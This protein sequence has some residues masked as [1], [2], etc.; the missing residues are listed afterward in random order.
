[1]DLDDIFD[2][3]HKRRNQ[4]YDHDYRHYDNYRHENEYKS[5][6]SHE[7]QND[8]KLEFLNQLRNNPKL[9]ILLISIAGILIFIA[10]GA[11]ILLF[12]LIIKLFGFVSEN[13]IEGFLNTIWKGSK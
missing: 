13:G 4:N 2:Q 10:I 8:L 12:P 3:G 6:P 1:M 11:I 7:K 9:K 5:H